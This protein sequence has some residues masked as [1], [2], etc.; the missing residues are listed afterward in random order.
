MTS[1]LLELLLLFAGQV[2]SLPGQSFSYKDYTNSQITGSDDG[3]ERL[4]DSRNG[5]V[6]APRSKN[7]ESLTE[8]KSNRAALIDAFINK[9]IVT[10][11]RGTKNHQRGDV[12]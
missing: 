6:M 10:E 11:S 2:L 9:T 5:A 4:S 1:Y 7:I 3:F 12:Q 8:T